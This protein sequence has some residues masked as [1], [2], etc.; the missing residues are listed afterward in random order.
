MTD[1]EWA[2]A[3]K[4]ET[5]WSGLFDDWHGGEATGDSVRQWATYMI[6]D[7]VVSGD[8]LVSVLLTA[9]NECERLEMPIH[10][11]ILR[12]LAGGEDE[13]G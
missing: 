13:A 10:A 11:A 12:A 3:D 7:L 6:R 9:S 8:S 4:P 5:N 2:L 1:L